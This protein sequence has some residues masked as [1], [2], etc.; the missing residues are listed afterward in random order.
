MCRVLLTLIPGKKSKVNVTNKRVHNDTEGHWVESNKKAKISNRRGRS[1]SPE[2]FV[3]MN[4]SEINAHEFEASTIVP[5]DAYINMV[6]ICGPTEFLFDGVNDC[7]FSFD[8]EDQ[9]YEYPDLDLTTQASTFWQ[10]SPN[11]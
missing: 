6:D 10:A 4:I 5:R 7:V 8:P 11:T 1:K 3:K 2:G 9:F